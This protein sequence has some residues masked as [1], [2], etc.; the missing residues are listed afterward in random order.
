MD[1]S[2]IQRLEEL[3]THVSPQSLPV[4]DVLR[5]IGTDAKELIEMELS[6][7]KAE[8]RA[9]MKSE[10]EFGKAVAFSAVCAILGL[11]AL[12]MSAILAFFPHKASSAAL[13][14]GLFLL[15]VAAMVAGTYWRQ[16][17]KH[18]LDTT[19]DSLKES[20]KWAKQQVS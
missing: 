7:A 15:L 4:K 14:V 2:Q 10:I 9:D 20:L 3:S 18:P 17:E 12:L 11:N 19:R 13:F 1:E 16:A 5:Q 6:L 8:A